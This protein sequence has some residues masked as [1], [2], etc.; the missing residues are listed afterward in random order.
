MKTAIRNAAFALAAAAALTPAAARACELE[1]PG[2]VHLRVHA[3]PGLVNA[4]W[5]VRDGHDGRGTDWDR[6][7]RDGGPGWERGRERH[8]A[9]AAHARAELR[10]GYARLDEARAR[11]YA[12]PHRR[13]EV[14]RFERWYGGE[15]AALDARWQV[16]VASR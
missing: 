14:R 6:G 5:S 3:A 12:H 1:P 4:E 8:E 10:A 2:H 16:L 13:W 15:R 9:R 11:F 7:G